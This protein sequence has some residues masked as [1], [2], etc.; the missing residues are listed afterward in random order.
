M[1]ISPLNS[2][3]YGKLTENLSKRKEHFANL[4]IMEEQELKS[5][6]YQM[7]MLKQCIGDDGLRIL[8]MLNFT[9]DEYVNDMQCV[10]LLLL[11]IILS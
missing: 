7:I 8:T 10:I 2:G 6:E 1:N 4:C 5:N 11:I 3:E 9:E